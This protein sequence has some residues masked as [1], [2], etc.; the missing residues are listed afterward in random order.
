MACEYAAQL[1]NRFPTLDIR[2]NTEL[3]PLSSMKTGGV[4]DVCCFPKSTDELCSLLE[5]LDYTGHNYSV[6]GYASNLLFL[7][8]G[9]SAEDRVL[10]F[11]GGV[12]GVSIDGNICHAECGASLTALAMKCA[13]VGLCGLEF[14]YGIPGS[15]GGAVYMNAGAYGGEMSNVVKSVRYYDSTDARIR[16]VGGE[17]LDFSYRHSFF[18]GSKNVILSA[19]LELEIGDSAAS[20]RLCEENMAKRISKQPLKMPSCGSAFKRPQGYFAG[21][22]IEQSGLKGFSIGGAQISEMHAGFIVNKGG[23]TTRDV[24]E[25]SDYVRKTVKERFGVLLEPEIVIL[26]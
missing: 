12:K 11:T 10:I 23:A 13:K 22:L 21:A 7:D 6:I 24:T 5:Y 15:V 16:T 17:S 1:K 25:L 9:Y 26:K 19:E 20:V 8:E 3:A 14:A 18:S 2:E 4:A